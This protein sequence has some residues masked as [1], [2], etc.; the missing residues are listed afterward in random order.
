MG[1]PADLRA[2]YCERLEQHS[3]TELSN[4]HSQDFVCPLLE[5]VTSLFSLR[6]PLRTNDMHTLSQ[7]LNKD[8]R[9]QCLLPAWS[10]SVVSSRGS[11]GD[12]QGHLL[13]DGYGVYRPV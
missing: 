11:I 13:E 4:Y 1:I 9:G 12:S 6:T 3:R 10:T 8:F 2:C 7:R 5:R